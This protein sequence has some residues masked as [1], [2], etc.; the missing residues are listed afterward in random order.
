[1]RCKEVTFFAG[2]RADLVSDRSLK[3]LGITYLITFLHVTFDFLAFKNDIGFFRGR[4]TYEGLSS[5]CLT[6]M[7][8]PFV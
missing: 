8:R 4:E 2:V 3:V 7:P 1:M 6:P 5:R